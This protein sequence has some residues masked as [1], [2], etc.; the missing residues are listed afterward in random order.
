M[1]ANTALQAEAHAGAPVA[2]AAT[3]PH[4]NIAAYKFITFDD[5]EAMRPQYQDIC[6]R[7]GLKGTIC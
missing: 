7:L 5:I 1:S 3:A 4:V 2:A 6:A